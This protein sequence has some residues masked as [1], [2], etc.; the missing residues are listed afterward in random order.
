MKIPAFFIFFKM[1][2]DCI[3]M[4]GNLH[5]GACAKYDECQSTDDLFSWDKVSKVNWFQANLGWS[6]QKAVYE[7]EAKAKTH[8]CSYTC[9]TTGWYFFFPA[10]NDGRGNRCAECVEWNVYTGEDG[11]LKCR[12]EVIKDCSYL[13]GG[14]VLQD[15]V[16]E[17]LANC[18]T[19]WG[20][21]RNKVPTGAMWGIW[22]VNDK[23]LW[24]QSREIDS[25]KPIKD[26]REWSCTNYIHGKN[27]DNKKY[28]INEHT[29]RFTC[30][31]DQWCVWAWSTS[32]WN[33]Y[34]AKIVCSEINATQYATAKIMNPTKNVLIKQRKTS[35]SALDWE[36]IYASSESEFRSIA[37]E[38][39]CYYRCPDELM[40]NG[41]CYQTIYDKNAAIEEENNQ[42]L[43][44][45]SVDKYK[46]EGIEP[47]LYWNAW[48]IRVSKDKDRIRTTYTGIN[49]YNDHNHEWCMEWCLPWTEKFIEKSEYNWWPICRFKCPENKIFNWF[50]CVYCGNETYQPDPNEENRKDGNPIGCVEK[51][52]G[53]VYCPNCG[54]NWDWSCK[55][56][57][58]PKDTCREKWWYWIESEGKCVMD[59][60]V[61][62]KEFS[63]R[64]DV[65]DLGWTNRD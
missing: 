40:Y 30:N 35:T 37:P 7:T 34:C 38:E 63:D 47:I 23:R 5:N 39:W 8:S 52:P 33:R 16:C 13:W 61:Y 57:E 19:R 27:V 56:S 21:V 20:T 3:A 46:C 4:L 10:S 36:Y 64:D 12:K 28:I 60:I 44:P 17:P 14:Y 58:I 51:C 54:E 59:P 53:W 6:N 65:G 62:A 18:M 31:D 43:P 22:D 9:N 2:E 25:Y 29:C 55:Y 15:G 1:F 49:S 24:Y 50:W 45:V 42:D 32:H 41:V 11:S 26:D 48:S